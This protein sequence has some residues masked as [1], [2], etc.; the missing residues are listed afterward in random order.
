[1]AGQKVGGAV[2]VETEDE[3]VTMLCLEVDPRVMSATPQPFTVRLDIEQVFATRSQAVRAAPRQRLEAVYGDTPLE[4][5]YTPDF[6]AQLVT[7]EPWVIESKATPAVSK[8][9]AAL[10][11]RSGVLNRLGFHFLVVPGDELQSRGLHA[12]LVHLR[13]AIRLRQQAGA[14]ALLRQL[15]EVVATQ[16]E[17]FHLGAIKG[18]LPSTAIYLGIVTGLIAC[19]LKSGNFGV[20]TKL[21]KAHG[22]LSH[23]QLLKLEA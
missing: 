6:V 15:E 22:D 13:D 10:P 5:I 18:A 17:D 19:D 3:I 12:N 21:W 8:A 4:R 11:R 23:L 16:P 9:A 7:G 20:A 2:F 14:R 1:M